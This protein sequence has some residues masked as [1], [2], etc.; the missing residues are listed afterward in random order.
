M[1][2]KAITIVIILSAILLSFAK[3]SF[4]LTTEELLKLKKS[5]VSE[6]IIVFMVE[7]DYKD[8]DKVSRLKEAGF[9]NETIMSVIKSELKN[10]PQN[11]PPREEITKGIPAERV[12]FETTAKI[13]ILWYLIYRGEPV[14]QNSDTIDDAKISIIDNT[15]IKFEWKEKGGLGLLDF[16]RKKPFK[17]PFYWNINRDDTF[18][19][20]LEGYAYMLKSIT[21][22]KGAPD[23]DGSHYWVVY[24]E[25][26]DS[27][28]SD[29]IKNALQ[30]IK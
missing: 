7:N 30:S 6:D 13:R 27:K 9:K 24:F 20:G 5:G 15:T 14:L 18:G 10:K 11:S 2:T 4:S 25:P 28:I 1:K 26:K 12:S 22:H 29:Y 16:F 19:P 21:G 3:N 8:V 17:S 23:T